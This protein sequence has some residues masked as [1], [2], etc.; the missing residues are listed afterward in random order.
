MKYEYN[1]CTKYCCEVAIIH[2][3]QRKTLKHSDV[4]YPASARLSPTGTSTQLSWLSSLCFKPGTM[5]AVCTL[6]FHGEKT[7]QRDNSG[8]LRGFCDLALAS[9]SWHLVFHQA[10]TGFLAFSKSLSSTCVQP[11]SLCCLFRLWSSLEKR[12]FQKWLTY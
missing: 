12:L 1:H 5:C 11:H 4:Y 6:L 2:I 7:E 10:V 9:P 3:A 8:G